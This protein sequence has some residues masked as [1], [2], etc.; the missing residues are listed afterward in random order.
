MHHV[1]RKRVLLFSPTTSTTTTD[2]QSHNTNTWHYA[3][4][5]GQQPN[6]SPIDPEILDTMIFGRG[7]DHERRDDEETSDERIAT[8][9]QHYPYFWENA[10]TRYACVLEPG[11]LLYIP[12]HWWHHVRSL[13]TAASV[14]VWWR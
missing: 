14:N 1:G 9:Q 11:D 12:K 4:H 13:E 10:P 3:G 7:K 2:H 5:E 6:T 8:H